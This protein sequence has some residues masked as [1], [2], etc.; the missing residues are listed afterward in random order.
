MWEFRYIQY[1][2]YLKNKFPECFVSMVGVPQTCEK[3]FPESSSEI[4]DLEF[5]DGGENLEDKESH[6]DGTEGKIHQSIP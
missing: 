2:P 5:N 3:N 6:D 4:P 1:E